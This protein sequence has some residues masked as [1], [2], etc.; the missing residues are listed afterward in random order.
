MSVQLVRQAYGKSKVRVARV[1]REGDRHEIVER[2]V[3]IS[4]D[5]DFG[6]AYTAAD[7]S[8]VIPTDTMKN[9]VYVLA[10]DAEFRTIESFGRL[11]AKHFLDEFAH[12]ASATVTIE[13]RQWD[14]IPQEGNETGHPHSFVDGGPEKQWCELEATREGETLR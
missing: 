3:W 7:N 11:L 5:G 12:I 6:A 1:L 10:R 2:T 14:R 8:K 9:T 4:L 13:Q